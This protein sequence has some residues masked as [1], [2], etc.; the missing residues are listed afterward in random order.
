MK[1]NQFSNELT[2]LA[3]VPQAMER[4]KISRKTLM[5]YAKYANAVVCFGRSVRIDITLMDKY[6]QDC[7]QRKCHTRKDTLE[8]LY[9]VRDKI[10]ACVGQWNDEWTPDETAHFNE[11][12]AIEVVN[13]EIERYEK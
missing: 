1:K 2:K 5:T 10:S 3:M 12:L 7:S 11:M 9:S 6:I 4:Y 13:K 8:C